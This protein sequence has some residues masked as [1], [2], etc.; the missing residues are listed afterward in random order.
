MPK[1]QK[2]SQYRGVHWSAGKG[3]WEMQIRNPPVRV[4][5]ETEWEAAAH[6]NAVIRALYPGRKLN[7]SII[8]QRG[9]LVMGR[10][11]WFWLVEGKYGRVDQFE[12]KETPWCYWNLLK[13]EW[14]LRKG[15]I[16]TVAWDK[17][18]GKFVYRRMDELVYG[19]PCEHI[20]GDP[21]DCRRSNLRPMGWEERQQAPAPVKEPEPT[22]SPGDVSG[23]AVIINPVEQFLWPAEPGVPGDPN[24]VP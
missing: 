11:R 18:A 7:P 2:T 16:Q 5:C 23:E 1:K 10:E 3:R 14:F 12:T 13:L 20:N 21:L 9:D 24:D 22:V 17:E 15:M 6:Y 8:S 19:G 4:F